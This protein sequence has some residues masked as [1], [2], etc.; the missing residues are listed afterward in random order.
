MLEWMF[1]ATTG[2]LPSEDAPG[3]ETA[4]A[5]AAKELSA[6]AEEESDVVDTRD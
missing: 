1:T 3:K 5:V 6:T 2:A 4:L